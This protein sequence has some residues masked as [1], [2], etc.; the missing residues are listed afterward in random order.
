[1]E[2]ELVQVLQKLWNLVILKI[3]LWMVNGLNGLSGH[4]VPRPVVK[5]HVKGKESVRSQNLVVSPAEET[6][7]KLRNAI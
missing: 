4:L 2:V 6:K 5:G 3:V 7:S 1:M